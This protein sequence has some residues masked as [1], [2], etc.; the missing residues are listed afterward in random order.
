MESTMV[1]FM[2]GFNG[3]VL[4]DLIAAVCFIALTVP[5]IMVCVGEARNIKKK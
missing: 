4:L 1:E 5:L 3:S 2:N